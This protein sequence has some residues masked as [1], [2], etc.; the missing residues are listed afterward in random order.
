MVSATPEFFYIS[1]DGCITVLTRGS[2][3]FNAGN[4]S[5]IWEL[6]TGRSQTVITF[7]IIIIFSFVYRSGSWRVDR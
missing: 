6:L 1:T 7:S 3:C 5:I 2:L 4:V